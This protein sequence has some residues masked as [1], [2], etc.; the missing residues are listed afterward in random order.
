VRIWD[1]V[2]RT[3]RAHTVVASPSLDDIVA[4]DAWA[5]REAE[6]FCGA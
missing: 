1:V 5:R 3:M 6:K 2:E 4:A